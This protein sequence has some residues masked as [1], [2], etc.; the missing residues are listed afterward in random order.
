VLVGVVGAPLLVV[1]IGAA[2]ARPVDTGAAGRSVPAGGGR[3][4]PPTNTAPP[5][6]SGTPQIGQTLT[7]S[8]GSWSGTAPISFSFQ[9][10]R[11]DSTGASCSIL[12]GATAATYSIVT[13][14]QGNTLRVVVKATNNA[15]SASAQSQPSGP[16]TAAS[17]AAPPSNTSPPTISGAAQVGQTLTASPGAWSGTAPISFA[18]QW[19]RC[20]SSGGSCTS[21]ASATAATY[22]PVSGDAG[23]TF[24]VNVTASNTA[25]QASARSAQT[26]SITAQA[27]AGS[28]YWGAVIDGSTYTYL[29]G[30]SYLNAPWDSNTWNLFE[31]HAGK[32]TSVI[33]WHNDPP[34]VHDFHYF[35][36]TY[37]TVRN[38]G[39]LSLISMDTGSVPLR[40]IANGVY[41]SSITTWAQEAKAYGHP[42]FLRLDWEM[43]GSWFPWGTTSTN[44]NTAAD[45]VA[46]WRHMHDLVQKA[47]A[48]N[49][50]WVWCPNLEFSGGVP[51]GQLYPGDAYVDWTGLDGY[52]KGSQ[53]ASFAS[54]Y[55]KSYTDLLSLAPGKPIMV[56]EISSKEYAAGVK[57][58]WTTDALS[59]Q[60]PQQFPRIK[61]VVWF[62][63]RFNEN[64]SWSDYEIESSSSAM[65]AFHGAIGSPYYLAGGGLAN[66]PLL[67][68]IQ[69][70]S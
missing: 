10:T 69:P 60:L 33:S 70:P 23:S 68:P 46:A 4:R 39:D 35:Q 51:Y 52:N 28:I 40:D 31:S 53:S 7:A 1:G 5:T 20:D 56:A 19:V 16:V 32:A 22:V 62:N 67:A 30:G 41:D 38:R 6:I 21:V 47:G 43:N 27:S 29:Y 44:Q 3:T 58:S 14:D 64:G 34:W 9:W 13:A 45:Y 37:E 63:W 2:Y 8:P 15:G 48:T 54:L 24:R 25:G 42:F 55:T 36:G 59:T 66:L 61:A 49:V 18:Y 50:T 17:A 57:A 12:A 11:C 65:Q 26:G